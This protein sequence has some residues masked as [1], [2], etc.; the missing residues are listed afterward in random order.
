MDNKA[1]KI[2][3]LEQEIEQLKQQWPAHSVSATLLQRLEEL[4]EALAE[5][6]ANPHPNEQ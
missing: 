3:A 5:A 2:A 1:V 6:Q 4:E